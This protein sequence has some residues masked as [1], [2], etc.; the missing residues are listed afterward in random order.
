MS[1]ALIDD[2]LAGL[3]G[4]LPPDLADE[5]AG[6]LTEA[7][8]RLL[9]AGS[10]EAAAARA[11]LAEFGDLEVV[12]GEYTR[13]A[14]GRR[15]ARLLLATGPVAGSC[16]AAALIISRAWTWPVPAAA[17]LS[18]GVVLLAAAA[19]LAVAA[20]SRRGYRRTGLTAATLPVILTLDAAAVAAVLLAAPALTWEL[21]LAVAVSLS[22]VGLIT[23]T[24]RR[25]ARVRPA[26]GTRRARGLSAVLAGRDRNSSR[27]SPGTQHQDHAQ[28]HDR[29]RDPPAVMG[30]GLSRDNRLVAKGV[31]QPAEQAGPQ[32][33]AHRVQQE[34]GDK[35]HSSPASHN[36]HD[37][38]GDGEKGTRHHG[39]PGVPAPRTVCA[40]HSPGHASASRQGHQESLAP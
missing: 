23:W 22:R 5:A 6:G 25:V 9:A 1:Q 26:A 4:R 34:E 18:F 2:Y 8:E 13:Q 24:L 29:D 36:E 38:P 15:A 28:C 35:P 12:V 16:W 21:A 17:R 37:R 32:Q 31:P 27:P 7:F 33:G 19:A 11:A 40:R 14:P 10:G 39:K 30:D 3:Y 20:T